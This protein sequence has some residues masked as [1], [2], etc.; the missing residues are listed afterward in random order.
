MFIGFGNGKEGDEVFLT[1]VKEHQGGT[2]FDASVDFERDWDFH[3]G[4]SGLEGLHG[5]HIHPLNVP[6]EKI[7]AIDDDPTFI[8][9]LDGFDGDGWVEGIFKSVTD[10]EVTGTFAFALLNFTLSGFPFATTG[11]AIRFQFLTA[12]LT[13][14][15]AKFHTDNIAQVERLSNWFNG[16]ANPFKP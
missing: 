2:A 14:P 11:I 9:N 13:S 15:I 4:L 5:E 7:A 16:K 8:G 3:K 1:C 12:F 6:Q 10:F